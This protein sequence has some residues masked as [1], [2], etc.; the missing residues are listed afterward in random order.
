MKLFGRSSGYYLFWTGFVYF[1]AGMYLAFTHAAQPEIATALWVCV[2]ALPFAIPPLGRY[3]NLDVEWDR[4]MFDFF[5]SKKNDTDNVVKFPELKSV[6][7]VPPVPQ[8]EPPKKEEPAKIYYR[9]GLTDNNRVA[10]QMGYTEIT[11]NWTGCQQMIDQ[12]KFF[13][14]QLTNDDGGGDDPDG[15][16]PLPLPDEDIEAKAKKTA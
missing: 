7:P 3:F 15:G 10:F 5:K 6:P 14:S 9:L 2:L 16:E 11:M 1:W 8:V 13:Q 12:L 4:R